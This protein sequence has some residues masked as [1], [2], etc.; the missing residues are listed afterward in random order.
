MR[1]G[2]ETSMQ[3]RAELG[4]VPMVV[5]GAGEKQTVVAEPVATQPESAQSGVVG[6]VLRLLERR[7]ASAARTRDLRLVERL[8]L[9]AHR[10][11][12]LVECHGER[13]LVSAS[14]DGLS[15]PTRMGGE[16]VPRA[17]QDGFAGTER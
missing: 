5:Y 2:V 7:H 17:H 4:V 6:F 1:I 11:L 3:G 10:Q 15:A 8:D 13:F 12:L 16:P 9:G 14:A